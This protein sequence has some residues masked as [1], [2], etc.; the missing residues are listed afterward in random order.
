MLSSFSD[1]ITQAY[2]TLGDDFADKYALLYDLTTTEVNA[3]KQRVKICI[4]L[5]RRWLADG[6][7]PNLQTGIEQCALNGPT[8][9]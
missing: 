5:S 4:D 2:T 7:I 1:Q 9:V 3:S 8:A 6:Y